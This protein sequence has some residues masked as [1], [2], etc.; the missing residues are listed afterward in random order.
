MNLDGGA[1]DLVAEDVKGLGD[2]SI[3]ILELRRGLRLGAVGLALA[4]GLGAWLELAMLRLRSK[5]RLPE[6]S[7]PWG[8]V[9]RMAVLG[10]LAVLPAGALWIFAST[11]STWLTAPLVVLSYAGIYLAAAHWAAWVDGAEALKDKCLAVHALFMQQ[12]RERT[13]A[14]CLQ[15][16]AAAEAF[17]RSEGC[18]AMPWWEAAAQGERAP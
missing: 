11:L 12:M 4:G 7:L 16:L 6:F 13:T 15:E 14:P 8:P 18:T 9:A 2:L 5:G 10:L 1:A 17:L 3:C